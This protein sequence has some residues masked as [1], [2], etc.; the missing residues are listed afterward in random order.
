MENL[1]KAQIVEKLASLGVNL[2]P[3]I[4]QLYVSEELI[5]APTFPSKG[6][7]ARALYPPETVAEAYAAYCLLREDRL[8]YKVV[9]EARQIGQHLETTD[10]RNI[11]RDILGDRKIRLLIFRRSKE[12]FYAFEWLWLK[13][14]MLPERE[15]PLDEEG[16][17]R[18]FLIQWAA[19]G[20][21]EIE[22]L[23]TSEYRE[24]ESLSADEK[25]IFRDRQREEK[26]RKTALEINREARKIKR[27]QGE[28]AMYEY[29]R[30]LRAKGQS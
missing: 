12:T 14:T 30:K 5:P 25:A 2:T 24:V 7:G 10:Y 18:N 16:Y 3:R 17:I 6:Q 22:T 20:D 8:S 19:G 4:L 1:D 29:L 15:L 28:E 11:L 9:K 26:A 13:Y 27:A 21:D 23:L